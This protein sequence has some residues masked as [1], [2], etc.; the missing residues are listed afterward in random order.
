MAVATFNTRVL[1]GPLN[2]S[3]EARD[4]GVEFQVDTIDVT[5][6][7]ERDRSF[8]PGMHQASFSASGPLD[9]SGTSGDP[10][11]VM[12][13]WTAATM[14]IT[15][16][17]RGLAAL[18]EAVLLDAVNTNLQATSPIA[19][20]VDYSV[21]AQS[22]GGVDFGAVLEDLTAVTEDGNGT[23]RDLTAASS[24]G[25]V[26]HLHVTEFTGLTSDDITIEGSANGSTGWTTI[27][28][29][30]QVT[31]VGAQRVAISGSVPRYLRVVDDVDGIGS[32]TRS[33]SFARR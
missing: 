24:N 27:L 16:A 4:A 29:F 12:A 1:V 13:G 18:S 5:T 30:A 20:S 33:V 6:L 11:D 31:G 22:T 10:F 25:G 3:C 19:G 7:C 9:V 28:T 15:Y 2:M 32:I 26:A 23:A 17:P 14:P 8:I 21:T